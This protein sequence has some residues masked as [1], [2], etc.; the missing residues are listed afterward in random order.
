M[1][2]KVK[3]VTAFLSG[4]L[5]FGSVGAYAA[6]TDLI[7]KPVKF[8]VVVDGQEQKFNNAI[9]SINGT[10]YLSVRDTAE[11]VDKSVTYNNGVINIEGNKTSGNIDSAN[12]T[13]TIPKSSQPVNEQSNINNFK[14]LPLS[15][16][17]NNVTVTVSSVSLGE[18]STDLSV[19]ITN[20]NSEGTSIS[21]GNATGANKNVPGKEY[22]VL[23][24]VRTEDNFPETV[25]ANS[26]VEG[27]IRKGKVEEGTEN[28][29]FHIEVGRDIFSF[30]IDTKGEL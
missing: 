18:N 14:K 26:T 17:K 22:K 21:Y 5:L 29:L 2:E 8:K 11:A 20:N 12:N 30:Y 19:K 24:T 15:V 3:V 4:A 7:A 16:T 9:V 1:K 6:N 25:G 27:I 23:G 28:L 13:N 10:T